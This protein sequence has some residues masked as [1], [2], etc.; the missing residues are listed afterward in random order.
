MKK[1]L[2]LAL[3]ALFIQCKEE[4]S[5]MTNMVSP[6]QGAEPGT[7][8]IP[9]SFK[10]NELIAIMPNGTD[11][12]QFKDFLE[13]K[14]LKRIGISAYNTQLQLFDGPRLTVSSTDTTPLQP[15][16]PPKPGLY[17]SNY[18]FFDENFNQR[19]FFETCS[20]IYYALSK[21]VKV[22]NVDWRVPSNGDPKVEECMREA[23]KPV[24]DAIMRK[25]ALL[26]A[27]TGDDG[28][29]FGAMKTNVAR[30]KFYPASFASD[31]VYGAH[32]LSVGAWDTKNKS[33]SKSSNE[34]N[35]VDIYAPSIDIASSYIVNP[36]YTKG[37]SAESSTAYAAQ[38]VAR[39]AATLQELSP[40]STPKELKQFIKNSAKSITVDKTSQP[41]L[42]LD[43]LNSLDKRKELKKCQ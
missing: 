41:I 30:V 18:I 23:F 29:K 33:I 11:S 27:S 35:Y 2:Y 32:V 24:L 43:G 25:N 21:D 7:K 26:I 39:L 12:V 17:M 8:P 28:L 4:P 3:L 34:D 15:P 37:I 40:C 42:L 16:K 14:G 5:V 31:S 9:I 13:K 36:R 22:I 6:Y 10:R 19:S 20:S 1:L 38:Y